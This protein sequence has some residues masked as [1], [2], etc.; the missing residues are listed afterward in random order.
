M[1][2]EDII[3]LWLLLG[4]AVSLATDCMRAAG[5][6]PIP[7]VE[8]NVVVILAWPVCGAFVILRKLHGAA[9]REFQRVIGD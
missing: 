8:G 3:M 9:I 4:L 6:D 1:M 2:I 5:H 7:E